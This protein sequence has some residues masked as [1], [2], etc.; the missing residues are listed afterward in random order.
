MRL[1]TNH[2]T[3]DAASRGGAKTWLTPLSF[4]VAGALLLV[5]YMA[6]MRHYPY[7]FLWD[8]DLTTALDLLLIQDGELPAHINHTGFGLYLF[9][10]AFH[11]LACGV[12]WVSIQNFA[13]L[14][15]ALNPFPAMAELVTAMRLTLPFISMAQ[16]LA[17]WLLFALLF[18]PGPALGLALLLFL[19]IRESGFFSA[20]MIRSSPISVL[21]WTVA[22]IL[23]VQ[24]TRAKRPNARSL[25]LFA[26]GVLLGLCFIN[27]LQ[28]AFCVVMAGF[29]MLF[30]DAYL[31]PSSSATPYRPWRTVALIALSSAALAFFAYCCLAAWRLNVSCEIDI[32]RGG[33]HCCGYTR[34]SYTFFGAAAFPALVGLASLPAAMAFLFWRKQT[35]GPAYRLA[36]AAALVA[37]GIVASL[38]LHL[39]MFS[40]AG[41]GWRYLLTDFKMAFLREQA[42]LSFEPLLTNR[43]H[44]QKMLW[45]FAA[46]LGVHATLT[47]LLL[48]GWWFRFLR[49]TWQQLG[50]LLGMALLAGL[51]FGLAVRF[52]DKDLLWVE[53]VFGFLVLL[54]VFVI[55]KTACRHKNL[56]RTACAVLLAGLFAVN[57]LHASTL[58]C[59]LDA[60]YNLY[61]WKDYWFFD[62]LYGPHGEYKR[63]MYARY[64][65]ARMREEAQRQAIAFQENRRAANFI[66]QNQ[67]IPLTKI[68]AVA[69][70]FP[71]WSGNLDYR[72]AAYSPGLASAIVVDNAAMPRLEHALYHED[73]A[74]KLYSHPGPKTRKHKGPAPLA[75]LIRPDIDILLFVREDDIAVLEDALNDYKFPIAAATNYEV[76]LSKGTENRTYHGLRIQNYA[77]IPVDRLAHPYFSVL[78][79]RRQSARLE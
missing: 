65:T 51:Q 60:N 29:F 50:L 41:Q 66:F 70:G 40:E 31:P 24:A 3:Q 17:M 72:I 15:T 4:A 74:R 68:G 54:Y 62:G 67:R 64:P 16:V 76:V 58:T 21:C 56:L 46:L 30:L 19:G 7:Y 61:G 43:L 63:F 10:K 20:T 79:K 33:Y 25:C 73:L 1:G 36:A 5:G 44:L 59:R 39:L 27:K 45:H 35:Q 34:P 57:T 23:L 48:C 22:L 55:R 75:V 18:R 6:A 52:I 28:S 13:D 69:K 78:R 71:V 47:L 32:G 37:A 9:S 8:M 14:H 42:P 49:L 77:E 12:G 11:T 2:K 26:V 53:T 38:L